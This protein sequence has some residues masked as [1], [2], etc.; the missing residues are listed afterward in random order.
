M[1]IGS[2]ST[3]I[4]GAALFLG[5]LVCAP[6][7]TSLS[8]AKATRA[9]SGIGNYRIVGYQP[10]WETSNMPRFE[11]LTHL[12]YAFLQ[13]YNDGTLKPMGNPERMKTIVAAAHQKGVKVLISVGGASN[14]ALTEAAVKAQSKLIPSLEN[15]AKKYE[16][17]GID[18]DWEGP[19]TPAQGAAY[20][21]LMQKLSA[22]L[23]P[24]GK[25]LTTAIATWFSD[26]IP[27]TAYAYLDIVNIMSYD[28]DC[29]TT[30]NENHSTYAKA[31]AD[32]NYF[33]GRNVPKSKAVIG[34]PFYGYDAAGC[35]PKYVGTAYKDVMAKDSSAANLDRSNGVN[36]NGIETMKRKTQLAKTSASGIMIWQL[37][38]DT[39]D[40]S[41]LLSAIYDT[42]ASD[43][44]VPNK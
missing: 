34:V 13:V 41:S 8:T 28:D 24:K 7:A 16:F 36:Y 30:N 38:Q 37:A 32:L 42:F 17:D 33:L 5:A 21:A 29:L 40:S 23:R 11:K 25:L 9:A 2:N 14:T 10:D 18:I 15:F 39:N 26:N 44:V 6:F 3:W 1:R 19:Q 31:E 43:A 22:D 20:L 35:P 27:T 4:V 12:N